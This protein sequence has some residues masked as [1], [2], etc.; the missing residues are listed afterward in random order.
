VDVGQVGEQLECRHRLWTDRDEIAKHP[1]LLHVLLRS[2]CEDCFERVAIAMDVR[3][4]P[5]LHP[6]ILADGLA[7]RSPQP[8]ANSPVGTTSTMRVRT[9]GVAN[10]MPDSEPPA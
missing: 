9:E 5:E 2:V 3:Q 7:M 1:P 8:D 10:V 4:Q 6:K